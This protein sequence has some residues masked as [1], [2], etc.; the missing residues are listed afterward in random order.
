M[1]KETL[2]RMGGAVVAGIVD[3][4]FEGYFMAHP[5]MANVFPYVPTIDPLPPVDDWLVLGAS[6]VPLLL[7]AVTKNKLLTNIGEG[8]ICYSAPMI[9]HHTILRA[10]WLPTVRLVQ[11]KRAVVAAQ[12]RGGY[13]VRQGLTTQ[14]RYS[15]EQR[16]LTAPKFIPGVLRPK[17]MHGA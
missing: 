9:I 15:P 10:S 13:P 7:G 3:S 14:V 5:E 4:A 2:T 17:F 8:M 12:A 6:A 1:G 16:I 11:A